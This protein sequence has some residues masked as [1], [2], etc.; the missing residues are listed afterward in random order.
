MIF[1]HFSIQKLTIWNILQ[2]DAL[3]TLHRKQAHSQ[4]AN[5]SVWK[6]SQLSRYPESFC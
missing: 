1:Q 6:A 2:L 3:N 5:I 4:T